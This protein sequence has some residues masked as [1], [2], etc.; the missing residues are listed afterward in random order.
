MSERASDGGRE[1]GGRDVSYY[2]GNMPLC[3]PPYSVLE[4]ARE[5][6]Y[7]M[8]HRQLLNIHPVGNKV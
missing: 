7:A 4:V 2:L 3:S 1:G 8:S 6:A 5:L